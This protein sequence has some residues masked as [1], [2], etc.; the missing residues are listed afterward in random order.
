MAATLIAAGCL[1]FLLLRYVAHGRSALVA[2]Q[3]VYLIAPAAAAVLS[4]MAAWTAPEGSRSRTVWGLLALSTVF[5]TASETMYAYNVVSGAPPMGPAGSLADVLN[6]AGVAA[7]AG[8]LGTIAQLDLLG[9]KRLLQ[10]SLDVLIALVLSF[11]LVYRFGVSQLMSHSTPA[12]V[13]DAVRHAVYS[14][15]GTAMIV[16]VLFCAL[17][18]RG[19]ARQW[20]VLLFSGLFVY[21]S[22]VAFWPIWSLASV[23]HAGFLV[24][25]PLINSA[26]FLGYAVTALA[27]FM[28]V[29]AAGESWQMA[30]SFQRPRLIWPGMVAATVVFAAVGVLARAF[31][32]PSSN[33]AD[34]IVYFLGVSFAAVGMV[35]RTALTTIEL[36]EAKEVSVTDSLTGAFNTRRLAERI[37]ALHDAAARSGYPYSVAMVDLDDLDM[38][39][40]LEGHAVG[41]AVLIETAAILARASG[42]RKNVFRLSGDE[43]AVLMP[44]VGAEEAAERSRGLL[45]AVESARPAGRDVTASIGCAVCVPGICEP[46]DLLMRAERAQQWAKH[47]GKNRVVCFGKDVVSQ[48]GRGRPLDVLREG[49]PLDIARALSAAADARDPANYR[50]SRNVAALSM[51][52]ASAYGLEEEHIR[53]V[54]VAA[55]L[56]DVGK[57]ALPDE[58]LGGR[59]QPFRERQRSE[60]H[61]ALGARLVESLGVAGLSSWVRSHHERWDGRG[62][63]DGLVGEQIPLEARIVALADAYDGMTTG[64]RYGAPVSKAAALQELDLG[65]GARFDPTLAELFIVVVGATGALGWSDDWPEQ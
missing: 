4:M 42:G 49:P 35:G 28:R 40:R 31:L 11:T 61:A 20:D 51:L 65:I 63:P 18:V 38:L 48:A 8:V 6:L 58:M 34:E 26:Y 17:G 52:L 62:Y 46:H 9:G 39:N 50:H 22:G 57:I 2:A 32:K 14:S 10:T 59:T 29:R 25:E 64:N 16:G 13:A 5:V 43:F 53:R 3:A 55:M 21:A 41:D 27:A 44:G 7:F 24:A 60:E 47:H 12:E 36:N 56:H 15:I 37:E 1:A 33:T 45:R 54:E 30:V 23:R 19:R